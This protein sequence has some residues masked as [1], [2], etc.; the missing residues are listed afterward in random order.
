MLSNQ[1]LSSDEGIFLFRNIPIVK[2][3]K[4]YL[5][6]S[7]FCK[8]I[9]SVNDSE[10]NNTNVIRKLEKMGFFNKMP[11]KV[12]ND[13]KITIT[14]GV[15][16]DCNFGCKYCYGEYGCSA[17][18]EYMSQEFAL[19]VLK[20]IIKPNHEE[21]EITFFG[22]EPT[23][24]MSVIKNC[25][26]YINSLNLKRKHFHISTNGT[27]SNS[28]LKYFL[29]NNFTFNVSYD[30]IPEIQNKQR[31]FASGEPSC[32]VVEET[33]KRLVKNNAKF[34]VKC[35]V[36][37]YN[38][39]K[40]EDSVKHIASLGVKNIHLEKLSYFGRACKEEIEEPDS[41]SFVK[42]FLNVLDLAEVLRVSLINSIYTNLFSP[43]LY[44]CIHIA[45]EVFMVGPR[46]IVTNCYEYLDENKGPFYLG[47]FENVNVNVRNKIIEEYNV[48]KIKSCEKCSIKYICG[49]GCPQ[50]NY[51]KTGN[52][53]VPDKD[54]CW[55][56]KEIIRNVIIKMY[57]AG[58]FEKNLDKIDIAP[59]ERTD[60]VKI[61]WKS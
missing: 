53:F 25:V 14:L 3:E 48:D 38:I 18:K 43:S 16:N 41:K 5:F 2:Y 40:L 39:E 46:G 32:R 10:L 57:N 12:S 19:K 23:L 22:G 21:I 29:K 35:V 59:K 24:N 11:K 42:N 8:K 54:E 1:V 61:F 20:K 27:I 60:E 49:G 28:N 26:E 17:K 9:A 36:T 6:F 4:K 31:P 37:K 51:L 58:I 7:P 56:K 47:N 15:T 45:G 55:I 13:N 52:M 33:I 44:Y 34:K 30:G 50:Q